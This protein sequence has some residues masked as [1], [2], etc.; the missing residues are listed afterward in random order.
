MVGRS[1]EISKISITCFEKEETARREIN[2][3]H[4]ESNELLLSFLRNFRMFFEFLL[5]FSLQVGEKED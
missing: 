3:Y 1:G 4:I 5:Q 2:Y